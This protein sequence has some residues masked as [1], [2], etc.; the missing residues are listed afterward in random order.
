MTN[1]KK[2]KGKKGKITGSKRN[3]E[4]TQTQLCLEK[5]NIHRQSYRI[6]FKNPVYIYLY[7]YILQYN[8]SAPRYTVY[9]IYTSLGYLK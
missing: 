1:Q 8:Y 5:I 4:Q 9:C 2:K 7:I 3:T 6:I